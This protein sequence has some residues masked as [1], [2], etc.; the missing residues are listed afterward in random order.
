M[1]KRVAVPLVVA[2][3]L[4]SCGGDRDEAAERTTTASPEPT[5]VESADVGEG[6]EWIAFHGVSLGFTLIRPDGMGNHVILDK[7]P[8]DQLHPD[9]SPDGSQLAFV[10]AT[11][12]ATWDIWIS[13]PR[14]AN[15]EPLLADYPAKLKGLIWDNP[16]W[17]RDGSQI[18]MIGYKGNPNLGLPT[19]SV[20]AIV[21]VA[22]DEVSVAFNFA[23]D[24]PVPGLSF[25]RWSPDGDAMVL[26]VGRFD[27]NREFTGEA[28]AVTTLKGDTWSTPDVITP[29]DDFATRPDWHP[30]EDLIVFGTYDVGYLQS[31]DEPSNLFTVR[32]DGRRLT[33]VTDFG[34]G[35]ERASQPTWTSDGRIIFTHISGTGDRQLSIAFINRDG[36]GLKRVAGPDAVG[37]G[38]RP[39][40]R[41]R[42]VP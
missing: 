31:T 23:L 14:G 1:L 10:Q 36:S 7:L 38:N 9:W 20:L 35:E 30:T 34:P 15:P 40:P 13:D 4:A 29:F 28:I 21:D 5:K 27:K 6:E 37:E 41:L 3:V 24:D 8:G 19:R 39:H 22:T 42:P 33:P 16:A 18:A 32:P 25:P 2:I 17:S 12:D 26:T 11:D